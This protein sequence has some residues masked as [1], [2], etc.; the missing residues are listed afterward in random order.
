[1]KTALL[2]LCLFAA[3]LTGCVTTTA[4]D[5]TKTTRA[6]GNAIG[7]IGGV[8]LSMWLQSQ[9]V[10]VNYDTIV[11]DGGKQIVPFER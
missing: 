3:G 6:D 7:K 11:T 4:P 8:A 9:G 1:M 10:P 2:I 5:G